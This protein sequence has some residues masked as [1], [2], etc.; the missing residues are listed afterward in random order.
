M[1]QEKQ[2]RAEI[3]GWKKRL[4]MEGRECP[5]ANARLLG[6]TASYITKEGKE[7]LES[8]RACGTKSVSEVEVNSLAPIE[9]KGF[10]LALQGLEKGKLPLLELTIF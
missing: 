3:N 7:A 10:K 1:T 4:R 9:R 6:K 8:W 5:K 2:T